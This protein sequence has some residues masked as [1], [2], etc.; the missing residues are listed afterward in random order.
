MACAP[1]AKVRLVDRPAVDYLY[2]HFVKEKR[3]QEPIPVCQKEAEGI[4]TCF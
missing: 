2:A 3:L 1:W 4:L